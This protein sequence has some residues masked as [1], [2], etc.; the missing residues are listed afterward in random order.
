MKST[1]SAAVNGYR[2]YRAARAKSKLYRTARFLF[3]SFAAAYFLLLI[4]PQ[5]LF[6][7]EVSYKN[8]TVYSRQPIDANVNVVLDKVEVRLASSPLYSTDVK[9]KIFLTNSQRFYSMLSLYI[10][11][12]SFAR[13]Y[14]LLPTSNVFVNETDVGQ[15]LVFRQLATFNQRSLSGVLSHEVTHL[16]IKKR[17]GYVKNVTLPEWKREGYCEY[18]SGGTTLDYET[19]ARMWK[20]NPQNGTGYQYF[21]Y[22]LMVKYLLENENL[23]VDEL[24][25]RDID[26]NALEA[27][28]LST[29]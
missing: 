25:T 27:K 24:F 6:A 4:Y 29:L 28:V 18:V 20:A 17:Y 7:H 13:G 3:L 9:P 2:R 1:L 5:I 11:W 16:L 23:T 10:S 26:R 12:N 22:Y 8:F 19:G 21:K 15:D 14:A